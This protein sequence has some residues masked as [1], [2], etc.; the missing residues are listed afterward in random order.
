MMIIGFGFKIAIGSV[1]RLDAGRLRRRA[2][3]DHGFYGGRAEGR[4]VR[5]VPARFRARFSACRGRAGVGLSARILD[6]GFGR[7]GDPDDDGRQYRRHRAKQRQ[8][9]AGVFVDRSRRLCA[10]RFYRRGRGDDRREARRSDRLGRVLYADLRGDESRRV[11]HR[12]A[13][14]AKERP[15]DASLKITTA[16][17]SDRRCWRLRFRY[18]CC[19]LLGLAADGRFYG[20]SSGFSSGARSRQSAADDSGRGR[21]HQHA[22]FRLIIICD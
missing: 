5:F 4:G 8:A 1:S 21:G 9:N 22:R 11:C 15:P 14:R 13:A 19:R 18:L 3:A 12:H 16:S 20:Q 10:G 17:V 6:H 2:D 7:N